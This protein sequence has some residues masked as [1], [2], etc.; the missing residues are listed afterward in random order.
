MLQ[1]LRPVPREA[2]APEALR[3]SSRLNTALPIGQTQTISQPVIVALMT[4]LLAREPDDGVLE[5]G[6]GS[7]YQATVQSRWV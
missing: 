7:G 3:A 6:T 2:F 4:A 1:A 5:I